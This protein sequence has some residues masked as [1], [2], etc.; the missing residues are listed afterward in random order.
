MEGS[1]SAPRCPRRT[2]AALLAATAALAGCSTDPKGSDAGVCEG[3]DCTP[4]GSGADADGVDA[5]PPTCAAAVTWTEGTPAFREV[6]EEWGLAGVE[7]TRLA[8]G[9]V[10]GDGWVDLL[11]RRGGSTYNDYAGGTRNSWL[12]SNDHGRFVDVTHDS[13]LDDRRAFTADAG[14]PFEVVAFGDVDN[15]GDLDVYTGVDTYNPVA[16]FGET[17]ELM[18]N[19]GEGVFSFASSTSALRRAGAVDV[20]GGASFVDFDRDGV[21]DL[22]VPQHDYT[23]TGG[24]IVFAQ[25]R[26]Y[27][28][29]G[30]GTFEDVTDAIGL[31]T[32]DWDSRDDLDAG[33]AHSRAWSATACDLNGDGITE[34]LAA[35]YGR[36]PNHLWQGRETGGAFTFMNRSVASGYAYDNDQSWDDN[37]FARCYCQANPDAED[38][39][40][41]GDPQVVCSTDNWRHAE[42]RRPYRLGGNSG[43][44]V[45]ADLDNDGDFDLLTTEIKH[46]W[47]GRGADGSDLLFNV[48]EPDVRFDRSVAR[49]VR[50]FVVRHPTSPTW[51]EGHMTA[52]A[53]DFDNDGWPDFYVGGSDYAGNYGLLYHQA[54]PGFWEEVPVEDGIDHNRSHGV[55]VADF[56]HDGDLDVIVGHSRARCDA[57]LPND[58][59]PTSQIRAFENVIGQDGN[60]LQLALV[61]GPGSNRAAIG[62]RVTV[63]AGDVTQTQ[64]VGGGYGH[65]GAQN[66]TTLHFGLGAA[67]EAEVSIR[68]PD[69]SLTVQQVSLV[70]GHRYRVTQGELPVVVD[71]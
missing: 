24:G 9:D 70:G 16:V 3:A 66:D 69:A 42:D 55:V 64:E 56:D 8:A 46:W 17:S 29:R 28:G 63:R 62:A 32:A 45:C 37:Q 4:D 5:A 52:A 6:T 39:A 59:Y 30:D 31:T 26:L 53:L 21:L 57:T 13:G 67:C 51:D 36:A 58:C 27:R 47:A 33:L 23:P 71:P 1:W 48:G 34:L 65:F 60:W 14:R 61:G 12:L 43:A 41:I 20:P 25:D 38:C 22:W 50:G 40:G 54:E 35:S 49:E 15:D 10:D 18:L 44:T 68:W 2:A 7:G 11:V 19:N